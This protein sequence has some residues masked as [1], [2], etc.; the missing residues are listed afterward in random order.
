MKSNVRNLT[1]TA[2]MAAFLC[3]MG[4]IVIPIGMVPV[5]FANMAIYLTIILLDKKKAVISVFLYLLIGFVGLPVFAGFTAG[6]GKIL[7]PTGGY[8][9]GYLFLSWIASDL[10]QKGKRFLNKCNCFSFKTVWM[11]NYALALIVGTVVLYFIGSLWLMYQS[12]ISLKAAVMTG[13]V[14]FVGL[15][16]IKIIASCMIGYSVRK[17]IYSNA[18]SVEEEIRK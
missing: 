12:N 1:L 7:G 18:W 13:V 17:R 10:S 11:I 6:A 8:L 3:I 16:M 4:P 15:D 14:P 2:F 5:S 9:L